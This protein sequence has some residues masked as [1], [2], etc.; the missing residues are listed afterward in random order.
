MQSSR[1]YLLPVYHRRR[2]TWNTLSP[3]RN[4]LEAIQAGD[5]LPNCFGR[6]AQVVEVTHRANDINDKYF[7]CVKLRI[8][9]HSTI[10]DSY[11]EMQLHRS[12]DLSQLHTSYELDVIERKLV[13]EMEKHG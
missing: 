13:N 7:I 2:I 1:Q 10:T 8:S 3:T 5:S 12:T 6:L 4:Q 9:E 11:K